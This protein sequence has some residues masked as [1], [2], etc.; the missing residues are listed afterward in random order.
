MGSEVGNE[1]VVFM[2]KGPH[3]NLNY[4]IGSFFAK[5]LT[6][7]AVLAGFGFIFSFVAEMAESIIAFIGFK[8]DTAPVPPVAT[9]GTT[10]GNIFLPPETDG[11]IPALARNDFDGHFIDE[12]PQS[13]LAQ[14][15]N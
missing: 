1:A 7:P 15:R 2:D 14:D 10:E 5:T 8:V 11:T 6:A 9:V 13:P 12:H 4:K 3:G